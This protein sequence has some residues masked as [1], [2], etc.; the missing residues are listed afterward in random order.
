[1]LQED[2][3]GSVHIERFRSRWFPQS[4]FIAEDL[5]FANQSIR[6]HAP[7]L[8]TVRKAI[9]RT[10]Y[11]NLFVRP[12]HL[13][14]AELEGLRVQVPVYDSDS[15]QASDRNT[16]QEQKPK[17]TSDKSSK[18]HTASFGSVYTQDVV[19]EIDRSN[20]KDPLL[21]AV[22]RLSLQSVSA[23]RPFAYDG[24]V[25][26]PLPPGEIH[27]SRRFG[28]WKS[29]DLRDIPL[30]GSYNF[31]KTNLDVFA[32]IAG[33]LSSVSSFQGVL[34]EIAAQGNVGTA[35][36]QLKTVRHPGEFESN[37]SNENKYYLRKR[38][39][40]QNRCYFPAYIVKRGRQCKWKI[41]RARKNDFREVRC[42]PRTYRRRFAPL[43]QGR[44][45]CHDRNHRFRRPC[46][47]PTGRRTFLKKGGDGG[48]VHHFPSH[49]HESR[50]ASQDR[51]P[52]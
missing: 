46:A 48:K 4:G 52:E 30:S 22:H 1:M 7:L 44:D 50:Y 2:W 40:K 18:G 15:G 8:V 34:G 28:P 41:G 27:T 9:V 32:G 17:Q 10:G 14:S 24:T 33:T 38:R 11:L 42:T 26:N 37:I 36:F 47:S 43:R 19:L 16:S 20:G 35:D 29:K 45:C 6:A 21:F 39:A 5:V 3:P 25:L 51:R 49:R 31:E 13:S 23:D 12:G